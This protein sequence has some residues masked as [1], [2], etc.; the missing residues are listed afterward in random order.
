MLRI[1]RGNRDMKTIRRR[2]NEITRP[3]KNLE[4]IGSTPWLDML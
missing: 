1:Y 2:N 4:P 3:K